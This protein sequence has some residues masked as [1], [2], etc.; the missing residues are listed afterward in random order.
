[1]SAGHVKVAGHSKVSNP[2]S[3]REACRRP[4]F[5]SKIL[6]DR[7][8]SSL[9]SSECLS[10]LRRTPRPTFKFLDLQSFLV[11]KPPL[12]GWVPRNGTRNV[13][14]RTPRV[15]ARRLL[16][17][18]RPVRPAVGRAAGRERIYALWHRW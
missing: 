3:R 10:T 12:I 4:F 1:M 8:R 18:M 11:S 14:P 13:C 6:T 17:T 5:H 16:R 9:P 2:A 7:V 15:V